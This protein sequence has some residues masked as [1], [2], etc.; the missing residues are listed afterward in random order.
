MCGEH[1]ERCGRVKKGRLRGNKEWMEKR[2]GIKVK[3]EGIVVGRIKMG[4]QRWRIVEI[5][6][7]ENM[8]EIL[9]KLERWLEEKEKGRILSMIGG[10]FNART[11][12]EGGGIM[13]EGETDKKRENEG[14]RN[15][16]SKDKKMNNEGKVL[17]E[18]LEKKGWGILNGCTIGDEEEEFMFT[19]GKGN[20]VID[21]LLRDEIRERVINLKIGERI[22]SDH[23]PVIVRIGGIGGMR[24]G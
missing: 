17:V 16:N 2:S 10:D 5:Y 18:F 3:E 7:R 21:Y 8:E 15:R 22:D 9:K 1:N 12:V 13:L 23:Q 24:E 20:T 14:K 4:E 11:G 19:G 6:V